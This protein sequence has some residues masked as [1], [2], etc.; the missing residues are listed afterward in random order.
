MQRRRFL[1]ALSVPLAPILA[2]GC[3]APPSLPPMVLDAVRS[4]DPEGG[5][6]LHLGPAGE[7]KHVAADLPL[8]QVPQIV[9]DAVDRERPGGRVLRAERRWSGETTRFAVTKVVDALRHVF[10]IDPA[11][12]LVRTEI[13]IPPSRAPQI[14]LDAGN[15]AAPGG[16]LL[17]VSEVREGDRLEYLIRKRNG[18]QILAVRVGSGGELRES[19]REVPVILALPRRG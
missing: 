14:I 12:R 4:A 1:V 3:A 10:V 7:V 13:E 17:S 6:R 15:Q 2:A 16:S 11:G 19:L 5:V 8:E 9:K 18:E